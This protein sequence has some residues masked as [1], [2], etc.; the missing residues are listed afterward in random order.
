MKESAAASGGKK[1]K[2]AKNA[3][4][5]EKP[6]HLVV[7]EHVVRRTIVGW[8]IIVTHIGIQVQA[9][10][11]GEVPASLVARMVKYKLL[12][13]EK[14]EMQA[15][16]EAKVVIMMHVPAKVQIYLLQAAEEAAKNVSAKAKG[17]GSKGGKNTSAS[18]KKGG[19][20]GGKET[21]S[22]KESTEQIIPVPQKE[23]TKLR[24]RGEEDTALQ[25]I[26][27]AITIYSIVTYG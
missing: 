27:N 2:Q 9:M 15:R 12:R 22:A 16:A 8:K 7:C 1:S 17:A 24:K 10:D 23:P 21:P 14:K 11:T 6:A 3:P 26:G 5:A 19:K 25:T 18:G 20:G 4:A 13:L